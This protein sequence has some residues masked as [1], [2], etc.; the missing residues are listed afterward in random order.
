MHSCL[1]SEGTYHIAWGRREEKFQW[2][3]II[4][5]EI[6]LSQNHFLCNPFDMRLLRHKWEQNLILGLF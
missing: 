3:S 4:S 5:Q 2:V 6:T 1:I